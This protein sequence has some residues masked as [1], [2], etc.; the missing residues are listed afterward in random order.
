MTPQ[1][2][3]GPSLNELGELDAGPLSEVVPARPDAPGVPFPHVAEDAY[4]AELEA[5]ASG[6][7]ESSRKLIFAARLF[8]IVAAGAL[9]FALRHDLRFALA[10]AAAVELSSQSSASELDGGAHRYVAVSGVP[11]GVGAVDYRR[12]M[13]A[14]LYRLAPLV[15]RPD[16]YVELKL[17]EG[18]GQGRFVP[19]TRL[20]G[21]LVPLDA[22]GARFSNVRQLIGQAT[23]KAPPAKAW[24][25]EEGA[26]P[27]LRAPGAVVALLALLVC[28]V[29]MA[30]IVGSRR[31]AAPSRAR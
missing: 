14:G 9:A 18:V 1:S 31:K 20:Q 19:P 15:D 4:D 30:M 21:R 13:S 25:L 11:G 2:A 17:P 29:Q 12:P 28:A 3:T 5:I 8:S 22:G 23:G 26:V 10:P 27:S 6:R 24:L 16:V 7:S